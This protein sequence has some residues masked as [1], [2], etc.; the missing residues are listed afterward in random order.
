MADDNVRIS[1]PALMRRLLIHQYPIGPGILTPFHGPACA[2]TQFVQANFGTKFAAQAKRF[3]SFDLDTV[4]EDQLRILLVL[5]GLTLVL[6]LVENQ[7]TVNSH[8]K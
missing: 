5:C 2:R 4:Q 1:D 7:S 6:S 3:V 8:A